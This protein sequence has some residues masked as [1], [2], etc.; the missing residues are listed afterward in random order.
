MK[1]T[2]DCSNNV[3]VNSEI[4]Y[5]LDEIE[6][7]QL[8]SCLIEMYLDIAN[9]C[10][11]Y[12]LTI[13]LCGGSALGAI[14]HKGFIPWDD[15]LDTMMP[16]RDYEK[17]I[18]IFHNEL[19]EK[20]AFY[21]PSSKEGV[22]NKFAKVIKK[23]TKLVDIYNVN[24]PFEKGVF[25]DIFPIDATPTNKLIRNVKGRVADI[26]GVIGTSVYMNKF[27]NQVIRSFMGQS[28]SSD[29]NYKMRLVVGKIFSFLK[30]ETWYRIF[31]KLVSKSGDSA[32]Y[33][34]PTGRKHYLGEVLEEDAF[35]PP[36]EME[37]EGEMVLVPNKIEEY[38]E[39]LYGDYMQIPPVE[40]RERHYF[41]EFDI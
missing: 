10:K 14:R 39:N 26:I 4:L 24:T 19:S 33:C 16:R 9:V 41:I 23:N 32:Y 27:D 2:R 6:R 38:L 37:F 7:Q 12:G 28:K 20:Y 13:M 8:Q 1:S 17:F 5:E 36:K 25:I 31:D 3:S 30:Y 18:Q 35:F 11:K 34:I 22:T 40:K 29:K 21:A 15:D